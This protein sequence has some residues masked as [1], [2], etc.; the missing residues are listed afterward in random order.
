MNLKAY[1]NLL[2]GYLAD[3]CRGAARARKVWKVVEDLNV[4][5]V[6]AT[7][8]SVRAALSRLHA[9]GYHVRVTGGESAAAYLAARPVRRR[10][11]WPPWMAQKSRRPPRTHLSPSMKAP[12]S[13]CFGRDPEKRGQGTPPN[14]RGSSAAT[15]GSPES[16]RGADA[17]SRLGQGG[18]M[19][20]GGGGESGPD[21]LGPAAPRS[22][23]RH[24]RRAGRAGRPCPGRP[25]RRHDVRETGE[26][27]A[28]LERA[29]L[30]A[31]VGAGE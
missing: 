16:A 24:A 5:G 31:G 29:P 23:G 21:R 13:G 7:E 8:R 22:R 6:K 20:Q 27:Y 15:S 10:R 25:A 26:R 28:G 17:G 4:L 12:E 19:D 14:A 2:L 9:F 3:H 30:P 18:A 11:F 1:H